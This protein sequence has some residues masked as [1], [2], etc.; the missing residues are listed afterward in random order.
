MA[1]TRTQFNQALREAA[2][3][4]FE[5]IPCDE[6]LISFH[7]SEKFER[8]MERLIMCQK[9]AYWKYVNTA[10][11]RVAIVVVAILCMFSVGLRNEETRASMLQWCENVYEGYIRYYFE[12]DTTKVIE[13]E[14]QL[15]VIPEGF[16]M[17]YQEKNG[18]MC[19]VEYENKEGDCI[20]LHQN[21]TDSFDTYVDNENG[22]WSIAIINNQEV[23]LFDYTTQ[24]GAMWVEDGYFMLLVY[25]G[26]DNIE[27]IKEMVETVQ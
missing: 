8:K 27:I 3:M 23:K 17:S 12:G 13:Y 1:M 5:D 7:F 18:E 6:G 11:K 22:R 24:M 21:I 16:E 14:Y 26:C 19:V 2:C 10:G 4:E 25:Y 20:S 9:K 15:T